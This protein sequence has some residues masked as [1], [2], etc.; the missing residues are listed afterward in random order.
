MASLPSSNMLVS[1]YSSGSSHTWKLPAALA[2]TWRTFRISLV[3]LWW[4]GS[5]GGI[6]GQSYGHSLKRMV[7]RLVGLELAGGEGSS[8]ACW[9]H[10][11]YP[12]L[13][14]PPT[15]PREEKKL[16]KY[17][18]GKDLNFK[19][20]FNISWNCNKYCGL[21]LSKLF[22]QACCLF[23]FMFE[24]T[25]LRRVVTSWACTS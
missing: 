22:L 23:L 7:L 21:S 11:T 12:T 17:K 9:P 2:S 1:A 4:Q 8:K 16:S 5:R 19:Y 25:A 24:I 6:R 15:L 14:P 20:Y 13:P 18:F 3:D 10:T